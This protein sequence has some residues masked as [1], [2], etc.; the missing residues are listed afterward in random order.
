MRL[1]PLRSHHWLHLDYQSVIIGLGKVYIWNALVCDDRQQLNLF[2][3][4]VT[5]DIIISIE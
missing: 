1:M 3:N 2:L 5:S 4:N